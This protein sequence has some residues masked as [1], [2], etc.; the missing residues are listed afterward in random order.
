MN[1]FDDFKAETASRRHAGTRTTENRFSKAVNRY[2]SAV[3][4]PDPYAIRPLPGDV[5]E[6]PPPVKAAGFALAAVDDSPI[7]YVAADHAAIEAELRG[8]DLRIVTV[9]RSAADEAGT[10]LLQRLTDRVHTSSA[11]VAV[12][13]RL[14]ADSDPARA[15]LASADGAGLV[16]VGHRHGATATAL[17]RSVADRVGRHHPGPVLVVRMPG[18]PAGAEFGRRP[19]V[20]AVDGSEPAGTAVEFALAEAR[21]R[22]C[23]LRLLHVVGDRTDLAQ[24]LE[25]GDGVPLR[26]RNISGDPTASLIEASGQAAAIVIG[27]YRRGVRSGSL[28]RPV[29]AQ[30]TQHALCPIFLVA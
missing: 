17:G 4:Y 28:L 25:S 9:R 6:S 15:L 13:S 16:V 27:R 2:L 22:G 7:S 29:A 21:A 18:W 5:I 3:S 26:H 11:A 8:W 24:R 19:L 10:A 23:E 20:V 1:D 14:I 12:S 30:L